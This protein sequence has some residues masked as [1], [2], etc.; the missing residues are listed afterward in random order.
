M[1]LWN[2]C[3]ISMCNTNTS[4]VIDFLVF[5]Y[6]V[7]GEVLFTR[8]FISSHWM[9]W[10]ITLHVPTRHRTNLHAWWFTIHLWSLLTLRHSDS[11]SGRC[12]QLM[13]LFDRKVNYQITMKII[14]FC[15]ECFTR[16]MLFITVQYYKSILNA[17]QYK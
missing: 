14:N 12:S 16:Q 17:A 8:N 15:Y 9:W 6:I 10:V 4:T 3:G 1:V 11:V 13:M 2:L 5:S 7:T